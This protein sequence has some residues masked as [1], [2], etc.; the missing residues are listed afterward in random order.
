MS[1]SLC[2]KR[3]WVEN[4]LYIWRIP[5]VVERPDASECDRPEHKAYII[6][7]DIG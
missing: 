2:G 5:C 6:K 7:L 4:L 3:F 1:K